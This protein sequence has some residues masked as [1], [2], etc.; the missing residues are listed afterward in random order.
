M[1]T[2]TLKTRTATA[3]SHAR[4]WGA[5]EQTI[6][7]EVPIVLPARDHGL[8]YYV[9][10]ADTGQDLGMVSKTREG[11]KAYTLNSAHYTAEEASDIMV[12][13]T[14][15][16]NHRAESWAKGELVEISATRQDAADAIVTALATSRAA[17]IEDLVQAGRAPF[18]AT[19]PD[20][21][22]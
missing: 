8:G 13:S 5:G 9:R 21:A 7:V 17:S 10:R 22:R 16:P 4:T 20:L 15:H 14:Q 6:E 12:R 19:R 11:W 2:S 3:I 18:L 1:A